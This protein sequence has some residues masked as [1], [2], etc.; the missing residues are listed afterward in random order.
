MVSRRSAARPQVRALQ[1]AGVAFALSQ[2]SAF[3]SRTQGGVQS[4][5]TPVSRS[6]LTRLES[7]PAAE[8]RVASNIARASGSEST[9]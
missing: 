1:G 5:G 4:L 8:P 9:S 3:Q 2:A 7:N 6:D